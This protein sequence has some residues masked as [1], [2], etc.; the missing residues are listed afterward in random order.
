MRFTDIASFE[1][2]GGSAKLAKR[3][4]LFRYR[5]AA[6]RISCTAIRK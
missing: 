4:T 5:R 3:R 6:L 2:C 1:S